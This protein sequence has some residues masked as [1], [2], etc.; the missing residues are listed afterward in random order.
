MSFTVCAGAAGDKETG[1]SMWRLADETGN[2]LRHSS[3]LY[4]NLVCDSLLARKR[5]VA[6]ALQHAAGDDGPLHCRLIVYEILYVK[7]GMAK[8]PVDTLHAALA[9]NCHRY[10]IRN[11]FWPIRFEP[12][13]VTTEH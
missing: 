9:G 10:F 2:R 3:E 7:Y 6:K 1:K 12:S 11:R 4:Y 8:W 5:A 13:D